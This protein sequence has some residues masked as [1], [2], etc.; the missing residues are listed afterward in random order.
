MASEEK[1]WSQLCDT[2]TERFRCLFDISHPVFNLLAQPYE[3]WSTIETDKESGNVPL[4]SFPSSTLEIK[5]GV[6][7]G[8]GLC[9]ELSKRLGNKDCISSQRWLV[10]CRKSRDT[11]T[12]SE[13]KLPDIEH[14]QVQ[15]FTNEPG[16]RSTCQVAF[17]VR[18]SVG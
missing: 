13:S 1:I 16:A 14:F 7:A 4:Q 3:K 2:C 12:S 10:G 5:Y 8:C 15:I 11:D 17:D 18:A 9:S 6:A